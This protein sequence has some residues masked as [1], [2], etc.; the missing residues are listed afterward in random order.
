MAAHDELVYVI[1]CE[2]NYGSAR[3]PVRFFSTM[4][5]VK[6][7]KRQ[8]W[9]Q[10]LICFGGEMSKF[11]RDACQTWCTVSLNTRHNAKLKYSSAEHIT[12]QLK[13]SGWQAH[14]VARSSCE[15][16]AQGLLKSAAATLRLWKKRWQVH[17]S[18]SC[19][20]QRIM[21]CHLHLPGKSTLLLFNFSDLKIFSRSSELWWTLTILQLWF[22][23]SVL[24]NGQLHYSG[25]EPRR[26]NIL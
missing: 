12:G 16:I 10:I 7:S 6:R 18:S 15:N 3:S 2:F 26:T 1:F 17:G 9:A 4:L 11:T 13:L 5:G 14:S 19:N 20:D 22:A 8:I 25:A 21:L 23:N 24:H